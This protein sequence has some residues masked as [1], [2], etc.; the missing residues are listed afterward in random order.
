MD[1]EKLVQAI[2]EGLRAKFPGIEVSGEETSPS[3]SAEELTESYIL[4]FNL[5]KDS[6]SITIDLS[7]GT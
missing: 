2:E 7:K 1:L 3:P 4:D 6:G 5:G